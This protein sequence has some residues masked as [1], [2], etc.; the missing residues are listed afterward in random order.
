MSWERGEVGGDG[1][2]SRGTRVSGVDGPPHDLCSCTGTF[3]SY[4]DLNELGGGQTSSKKGPPSK[5]ED[6]KEGVL[7][8]PFYQPKQKDRASG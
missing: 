3:D 7:L 6:E 2:V 4:N 8:I 5:I 1:C